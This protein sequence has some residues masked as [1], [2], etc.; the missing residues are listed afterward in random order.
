MAESVIANPL[1]RNL[2]GSIRASTPVRQNEH[3]GLRASPEIADQALQFTSHFRPRPVKQWR[4]VR[5]R[6]L[7][8]GAPQTPAL[9]PAAPWQ[10]KTAILTLRLPDGSQEQIRYTGDVAPNGRLLIFGA[11]RANWRFACAPTRN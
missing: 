5:V 8:A 7:N 1:D 11:P 9:P 6:K 10:R 3:E 2:F 4:A